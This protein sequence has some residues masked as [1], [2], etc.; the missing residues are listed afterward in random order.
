MT[1]R[2]ESVAGAVD[3]LGCLNLHWALA[4]LEGMVSAGLSQLVLSPGARSTPLLIAA[5]RLEAAGR[6]SLTPILDERSA[7]FF[8]LGLARARLRPVAL[9]ATSGSAPTHWYPAVIEAAEVGLPLLLLSADRPPRLHGWGANQTIDQTRLFGAFVRESFDPGLPQATAAALKA[10]CALGRRAAQVSCGQRAGPVHLNLPFDEPLVPGPDCLARLA[11]E[12]SPAPAQAQSASV[13]LEPLMEVQLSGWPAGRGLILCGPGAELRT[14]VS[15]ATGPS[16]ASSLWRCA[17]ALALPVLVDPLSGL[18]NGALS[19][20]APALAEKTEDA[21][22]AP[23]AAASAT[24]A[25]AADA[26]EATAAVLETGQITNPRISG[27][28]AFLRHPVL[29][30]ELRPDWVLR[31]GRTPVSKVLGRWL[32]GVPSILVGEAGAWSDPGHDALIQLE[33]PAAAVCN[34]LLAQRLVEPE[35]DWL[36]RW[37]AA[38]QWIWSL[39]QSCLEPTTHGASTTPTSPVMPDTSAIC[40]SVEC[41]SESRAGHWGEAQ[42]I[43]ILRALIPDNEALFC[44]NSMPIRQ[45][46][47]WWRAGGPAVALLGNRGTSGIDGYLSTLAGINQAGLTCWGLVGDLSLCHDLSGLLL[48][49]RLDR[50]LLVL[51]NGGGHIFDYLPQRGLADFERLWQTPQRVEM[52]ALARLGGLRHW[53]VEH[54]AGLDCALAEAGRGPGLIECVIDPE[55]SRQAHLAF[56]E[57]IRLSPLPGAD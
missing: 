55:V 15:E 12:C 41:A 8:A 21:A 46:D 57:S 10:Q 18:R 33:L 24:A 40:S 27:Y 2:P 5:Q 25:N 31:I 50:P 37:C 35:P 23:N 29:A 1:N 48:A 28:D 49:S 38:E 43:R 13:R 3:D 17:G 19:H 47:T 11:P 20:Q 6:L 30:S 39:A 16:L 45:I 22:N 34:A 4:L 56:W 44:A 14:P 36:G 52:A 51:N 7:A 42:I 32:E 9:L 26:M 53:R 54:A